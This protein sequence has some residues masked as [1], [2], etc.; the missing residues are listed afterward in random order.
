MG[1]R[2]SVAP[3]HTAVRVALWRALHL[4]LDS[5]PYIFEDAVGLRL[6]APEKNWRERP[7]MDPEGTKFFRASIL[8]RARF[9]ED[10]LMRKIQE[11]GT[12][13]YV[14][15]GAGLDTFVQRRPDLASQ[16]RVFEVDA[17][18]PQTWKINRLREEGYTTPE[19]HRFVAVDFES[20]GDWWAQLRAAGFDVK[21]PTFV[22]SA[23]VTMYLTLEA[24]EATLVQVARLASGSTLAMTYLLPAELGAPEE[25]KGRE[26]SE[27]G[28][29]SAGTPFISFFTPEQMKDLALR[30]GF[31]KAETMAAQD[32]ADRYFA[33]RTDGLRLSRS[34]EILVATV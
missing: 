19:N 30:A 14:L 28:A 32:L 9:I 22:A 21:S 34:E 26:M 16:L 4:E 23:G 5:K 10:L 3:E 2:Q 11:E 29:R 7:D 33:G 12:A 13:Q 25:R 17:P 31:A 24:I 18:G 1:I 8:A 20:K 27:K 15:L 6:I